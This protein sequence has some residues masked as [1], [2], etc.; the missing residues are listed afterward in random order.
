MDRVQLFIDGFNLYHCLM[1]DK[2]L[3][4]YRWLDFT[5][6]AQSLV[7]SKERLAG[8][9]YFTSFYPGD[10]A[11]RVRHQTFINAQSL[12]GVTTILGEFR[13]KEKYCKSCKTKTP[14][15][16]EKETDVNIAVELL[17]GAALDRYDKCLVLS[18]DSDLIPVYRALKIHF[19]NKKIRIIFPPNYASNLLKAEV[20]DYTRLKQYHLKNH[21]F[22]NPLVV[23][24]SSISKPA[25]W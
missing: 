22:P 4:P 21:Q 5:S 13:A 11:K 2:S 6:L 16:E 10:Q 20:P 17:L 25:G 23:G 14:G 12:R 9:Y 24:N 15:Y 19:P 1:N 8:I 7:S 18:N 3:R